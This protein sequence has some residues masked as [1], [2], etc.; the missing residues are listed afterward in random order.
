MFLCFDIE[1]D[2][3]LQNAPNLTPS[4]TAA[5]RELPLLRSM[6]QECAQAARQSGNSEILDLT[7]QVVEMLS[8]WEHYLSFRQD[9]ISQSHRGV[10]G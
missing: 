8:L 5:A 1:L 3:L 4:E 6:M 10:G 9:M 2:G 7:D